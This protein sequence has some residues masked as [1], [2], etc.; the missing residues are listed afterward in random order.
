[1]DMCIKRKILDEYV[2][3]DIE[4]TGFN[5]EKDNIIELAVCKVRN[6]R[7]ID[8]FT[9][10][11]N[12]NKPINKVITKITGI[13][14]EMLKDADTINIVLNKLVDFIGDL[15]IVVHNANYV[16]KFIKA[17]TNIKIENEV[18]DTLTLS[19]KKIPHLK[20]Y[21]LKSILEFSGNSDIVLNRSIDY[22]RVLAKVYEHVR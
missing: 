17:N 19:K 5:L 4:T 12:P 22:A 3:I 1:M 7:I 8:S 18:I 16:M 15:P 11:I 20:N 6:K 10:F 14:D 13:T 2:T 9:S 21:T